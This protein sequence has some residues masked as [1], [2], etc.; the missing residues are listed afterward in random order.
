MTSGEPT[1]VECPD[2]GTPLVL[3]PL[4]LYTGTEDIDPG[5]IFDVAGHTMEAMF[6]IV[7]DEGYYKCPVCQRQHRVQP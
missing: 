2:C 7:D 1:N 3:L 5:E 6:T 4:K